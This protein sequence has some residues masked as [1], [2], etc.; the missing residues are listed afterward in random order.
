MADTVN[1]QGTGPKGHNV[2]IKLATEPAGRVSGFLVGNRICTSCVSTLPPFG[3]ECDAPQAMPYIGLDREE[4]K[5]G[6]S[7]I[8]CGAGPSL[9]KNSGPTF[10]T[11]SGDVWATNSAL[12]WCVG[13]GY[14][15]RITYGVAIDA[16]A[17]MFN[18]VWADPPEVEY[19]IATS[20]NP[21][22]TAHL[23][24]NGRRVTQ[25]HSVRGAPDEFEL[26]Q[27]IYPPMFIAG[28]GLNVVNRSLMLALWLGYSK[29][30]LL[31][32]DH[33]YS[34]G[35]QRYA[36]GRGALAGDVFTRGVIDGREWVTNPDMLFC[37]TELVRIRNEYGRSRV[38]FVGDVLPR[39]LQD[40][41]EAFLSR[42]IDW[43][44]RTDA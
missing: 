31:G 22:L 15:D 7:L 36:D 20:V 18:D 35:K 8:I 17:R 44:E 5:R 26:Y 14:R 6:R 1:L 13:N 2:T 12:N 23:L 32:C 42:C 11:H 33:A 37:A 24:R 3:C 34:T 30:K 9:A 16:S 19:L 29:V 43:K 38:S 21:G 10:A 40:K 4:S 41:P 28:R 39:A 25:W 27:L